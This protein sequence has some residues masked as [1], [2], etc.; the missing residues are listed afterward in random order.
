[1]DYVKSDSWKQKRNRT[2]R[3]VILIVVLVFST[4]LGIL[5]QHPLGFKPAGVDAFCPF[6]G[7]ESAFSLVTT[8]RMLTA[9]HGAPLHCSAR[10]S[11]LPF[12][13]GARSAGTSARS[14]R[15]RSFSVCSE[16]NI[17]HALGA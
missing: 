9:L 11:S 7:I 8:G 4:T 12:C 15:F 5:H 1:M 14:E 3:L 17:R 10:Y 6:G 16:K 2:F 13:F